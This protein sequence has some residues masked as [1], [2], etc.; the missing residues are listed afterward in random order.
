SSYCQPQDFSQYCGSEG[1]VQAPQL[2]VAAGTGREQT[3][4]RCDPKGCAERLRAAQAR[5]Q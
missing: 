2:K 5:L 4:G 3:A 1:H